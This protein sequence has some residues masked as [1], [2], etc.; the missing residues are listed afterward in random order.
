MGK[1]KKVVVLAALMVGLGGASTA[2]GIDR[3]V[4]DLRSA[5]IQGEST[6]S[7]HDG[8]VDIIALNF[9]LV[10]TFDIRSTSDGGAGQASANPIVLNKDFDLS[11]PAIATRL[12][13]GEPIPDVTIK[14]LRQADEGSSKLVSYLEFHLCTVYVGSVSV[15]DTAA[16][17]S[18]PPAENIE[19]V[20]G[21]YGV[22][23]TVFNPDGSPGM[24]AE[25]GWDF[26]K[27]TA[28]SC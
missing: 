28:G 11:S 4:M 23:Y 2:W 25:A 24:Q 7:G 18:P 1:M 15:A 19:L 12:L 8:W 3:I 5:G 20:F 26:I 16:T 9:S 22:K 21:A 17:G 27:G 14:F 13:T 10:N 6:V